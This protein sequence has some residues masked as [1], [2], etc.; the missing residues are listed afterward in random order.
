TPPATEEA[1]TGAKATESSSQAELQANQETDS[2]PENKEPDVEKVISDL[3][4]ESKTLEVKST[5]AKNEN[6]FLQAA[7]DQSN[8]HLKWIDEASFL[9][10]ADMQPLVGEEKNNE[11]I[12]V[13]KEATQHQNPLEVT[14]R[15][16]GLSTIYEP[17]T[18]T[19]I[20]AGETVTIE[21]PTKT[22]K[23]SVLNNIKQFKALGKN[24]E[25]LKNG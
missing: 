6:P 25:V 3:T 13:Q 14:I 15:N 11:K 10:N 2:T 24:V 9:P 5:P 20:K 22:V 7:G 17:V 16:N 18:K 12:V 8:K 19:S 21:C 23:T 4:D 1:D